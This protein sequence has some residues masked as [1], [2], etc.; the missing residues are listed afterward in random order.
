MKTWYYVNLYVKGFYFI[1]EKI[2][3]AFNYIAPVKRKGKVIK[4]ETRALRNAA[5][6]ERRNRRGKK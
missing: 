3:I 6:R 5:K 4:G 1:K 2:M